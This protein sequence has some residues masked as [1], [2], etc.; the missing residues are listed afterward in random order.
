[1]QFIDRLVWRLINRSQKF[2]EYIRF[3]K[4][5][6]YDTDSFIETAKEKFKKFLYDNKPV[7]RIALPDGYFAYIYAKKIDSIEKGLLKLFI[8]DGPYGVYYKDIELTKDRGLESV[9]K[10]QDNYYS[11]S[12]L[13]WQV[14]KPGPNKLI[15][16]GTCSNLPLTQ[17]WQLEIL[18][19][20]RI[21][22]QIEME[23]EEK[24]KIEEGPYVNLILS[25]EYQEWATLNNQGKFGF[26]PPWQ[27]RWN[28]MAQPSFSICIGVRGAKKG[29][30]LLPGILLRIEEGLILDRTVP[31]NTDYL[32]RA[33]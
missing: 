19:D 33:R 30:E 4:M 20:N 28:W 9:F 15:V 32:M 14:E 27:K 7:E 24:I 5:A 29:R 6:I 13:S 17:I 2:A 11:S 26:I 12:Q 8:N 22:W 10:Y 16:K 21:N 18:E 1:A 31:Q 3:D 25:S 23:T